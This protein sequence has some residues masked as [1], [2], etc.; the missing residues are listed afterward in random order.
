METRTAPEKWIRRA[1]RTKPDPR[2]TLLALEKIKKMRRRVGTRRLKISCTKVFVTVGEM[3]EAN[4]KSTL[5][6]ININPSY[7]QAKSTLV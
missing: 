7:K 5:T 2:P 6:S 1:R 3:R 4:A